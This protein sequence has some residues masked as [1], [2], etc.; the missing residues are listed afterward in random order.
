MDILFLTFVF[1]FYMGYA[2]IFFNGY[3]EEKLED[4]H[5]CKSLYLIKPLVT[6]LTRIGP[7]SKKNISDKILSNFEL[8]SIFLTFMSQN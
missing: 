7:T 4:K 1:L 2:A 3:H 8:E 5:T 6:S